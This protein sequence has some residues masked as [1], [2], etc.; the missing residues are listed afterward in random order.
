MKITFEP[1]HNVVEVSPEQTLLAAAHRGGVN[2]VATCGGRGRCNSCR[3]QVLAGK[4]TPP[5]AQEV[6]VLGEKGLHQG[7]RLSCQTKARGDGSV[8]VAPPIAERAFHI[9][10]KTERQN[11]PV[12]PDVRKQH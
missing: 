1:E 4:L 8:R 6:K 11:Y 7:F 3:I 12:A 10:S 5:T 9:L 2:I